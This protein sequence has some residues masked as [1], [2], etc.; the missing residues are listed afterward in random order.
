MTISNEDRIINASLK[1]RWSHSLA[2]EINSLCSLNLCSYCELHTDTVKLVV[3]V[4]RTGLI[5]PCYMKVLQNKLLDVPF[6]RKFK[7]PLLK[8]RKL[9]VLACQVYQKI[10]C[11]QNQQLA[12]SNSN[13]S[14]AGSWLTEKYNNWLHEEIML[15]KYV[16]HISMSSP[17]ISSWRQ[18]GEALLILVH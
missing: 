12:I 14:P 15:G 13:P 2:V 4:R 16:T 7:F 10:Y 18:G 9:E 17:L 5:S 6:P 11:R 3:G 1:I 8:F